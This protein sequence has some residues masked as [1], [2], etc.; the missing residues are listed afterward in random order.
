MAAAGQA[1]MLAMHLA[2]DLGAG[3]Q[4]ARDD[5]G[6]EIG[7]IALQR[8][9]A[10]GHGHAGEHDVVLQRDGLAL[11]LA[12]GGAL[13]GRLAIPG[14]ARVLLGRGPIARRARIFH[15]GQFVRH[16]GNEI[17]GFDRA[18]HETAERGHVVIGERKAALLGDT[19][20]LGWRGKGNCHGAL[21]EGF[22]IPGTEPLARTP[23]G[24]G[25]SGFTLLLE[26]EIFSF[27]RIISRGRCGRSAG[28][29]QSVLMILKS[30]PS[31]SA[32][33]I[34]ISARPSRSVTGPRPAE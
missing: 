4:H 34:G 3:I 23:Q 14:I 26:T 25:Q 28:A 32:R 16:R 20:K 18:L 7:H 11:E 13:H 10:V 29:A 6:V 17:V 30:R 2:L 12:A 21:L 1:E 31:A 33:Y 9:R 8:R 5:G 27:S 15:F 22:L 19:A 24:A